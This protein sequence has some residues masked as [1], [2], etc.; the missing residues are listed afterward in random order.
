VNWPLWPPE[1]I[2]MAK[3]IPHRTDGNQTPII[4]QKFKHWI[5]TQEHWFCV[6]ESL[7]MIGRYTVSDWTSG[8]RVQHIDHI[9]L[10][11]CRGNAKDAARLTLNKLIEHHGESRVLAVLRSAPQRTNA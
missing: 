5:G 11:A 1:E 4:V 6:H 10:A 9:T 7:E 2:N 3:W 8:R